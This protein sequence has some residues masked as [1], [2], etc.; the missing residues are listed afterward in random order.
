MFYPDQLYSK[1]KNFQTI[2]E[3]EKITQDTISFLKQLTSLAANNNIPRDVVCNAMCFI[4][5]P[6]I[7]QV[8]LNRGFEGNGLLSCYRPD[9]NSLT[10][11]LFYTVSSI[12]S[13]PEAEAGLVVLV[14]DPKGVSSLFYK[15]TDL[16]D[17]NSSPG[18]TNNQY[19]DP[20]GAHYTTYYK[21]IDGGV[22][23]INISGSTITYGSK[24]T[25]KVYQ[26]EINPVDLLYTSPS[27]PP[28]LKEYHDLLTSWVGQCK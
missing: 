23:G 15:E 22:K 6:D 4:L 12:K 1:E 19:P 18:P 14:T 10:P 8:E 2:T 17:E 25:F 16:V 11:P 26:S 9:S 20:K 3:T 27:I 7:K 13:Y 28:S 24:N 5:F 21:P